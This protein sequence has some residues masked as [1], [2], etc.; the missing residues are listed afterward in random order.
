MRFLIRRDL[1]TK[2]PPSCW[3]RLAFVWRF[4]VEFKESTNWIFSSRSLKHPGAKHLRIVN[5]VLC[6]CQE[7]QVKGDLAQASWFV[8][9]FLSNWVVR[10]QF[11]KW[12]CLRFNF[13]WESRKQSPLSAFTSSTWHIA[14]EAQM[15]S[16]YL[17]FALGTISSG[18]TNL[19]LLWEKILG[20]LWIN[21]AE[22]WKISH[23]SPIKIL[24]LRCYSRLVTTALVVP[25]AKTYCVV[26]NFLDILL[27]LYVHQNLT[28][29]WLY[30]LWSSWV[31][32]ASNDGCCF[33]GFLGDY[34]GRRLPIFVA[35]LG[36]IFSA[37]GCQKKRGGALVGGRE[38]KISRTVSIP[39][40]KHMLWC[41]DHD[42]TIS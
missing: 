41:I 34:A 19:A 7:Y 23:F 32:K 2:G 39:S 9:K 18:W 26:G 35:Y 1:E 20:D 10:W 28:G 16:T 21:F 4:D 29:S 27:V 33:A 5:Y 25:V 38:I 6:R 15:L 30:F 11:L 13:R 3:I 31:P 40:D 24:A 42:S 36:M 14:E 12:L 22:V 17:G 37:L 8:S